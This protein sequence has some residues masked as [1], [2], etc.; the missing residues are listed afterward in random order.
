MLFLAEEKLRG[1]DL[2]Q[3]MLSNA[4]L[5]YVMAHEADLQKVP[6]YQF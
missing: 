5:D 2:N 3:S 6:M 1:Q 4:G